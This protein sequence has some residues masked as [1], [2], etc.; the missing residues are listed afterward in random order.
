MPVALFCKSYLGDLPRLQRLLTSIRRF[1]ADQLPV[2]VSAPAADHPAFRAAIDL[3]GVELWADETLLAANHAL[4]LEQ[5]SA[6]PGYVSQQIVKADCWRALGF[7]QYVCIDSDSYF[8]RPFHASDFMAAPDVPYQVIHEAKDYTQY[9]IN[10]G[11]QNPLRELERKAAY[12]REYFPENPSHYQFAPTPAVWDARVWQWLA[13]SVLS[14]RGMNLADALAERPAELDWYGHAY[15]ASRLFPLY[16]REPYFRVYHYPEWY[17]RMRSTGEREDK[18]VRQYL[19]VI[20]QSAWDVSLEPDARKRR[21]RR[22]KQWRARWFKS[23]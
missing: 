13:D 20:Q 11:K 21:R 23:W 19:G 7:A 4:N 16:P 6:L 2:H 17:W 15:L 8:I 14:P 1:N 18:L 9:L 5:I 12:F 10:I 22:L 3:E